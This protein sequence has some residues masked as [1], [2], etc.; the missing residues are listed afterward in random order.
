MSADDR[1][2]GAERAMD[3][4]KNQFATMCH[5]RWEAVKRIS[6]LKAE[7]ARRALLPRARD[8][9]VQHLL[10]GDDWKFKSI[11]ILGKLHAPARR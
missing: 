10:S 8:P 9:N 1:I 7:M 6:A 2:D 3:A 11:P 4:V 5:E